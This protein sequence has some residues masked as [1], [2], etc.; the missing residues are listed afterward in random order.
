[1]GFASFVFDGCFYFGSIGIYTRPQGGYRLTYPTRKGI[2]GSLNLYHP[3]NREVAQ[4]IEQEVI[5]KFE[6][7]TKTYGRYNSYD[8]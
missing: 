7:V 6:E 1:M 2:T 5:S 4:E 3:I 8:T